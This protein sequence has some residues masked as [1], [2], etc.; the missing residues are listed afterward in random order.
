MIRLP[1]QIDMFGRSLFIPN[2][3]AFINFDNKL[4]QKLLY[5]PSY[6]LHSVDMLNNHVL[7]NSM[8]LLYMF[9]FNNDSK[10]ESTWSTTSSPVIIIRTITNENNNNTN[11]IDSN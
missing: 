2:N 11:K 9:Y 7:H 8:N 1:Y 4:L 3:N 10:I 5:N 6:I